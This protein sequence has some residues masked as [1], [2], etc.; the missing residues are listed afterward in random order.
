MAKVYA[1]L[2]I[3]GCKTIN[4]VPE[5]IKTDVQA[6]LIEMGY[7]ELAEGDN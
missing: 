1:S 4:D 5:K 7:P 2:I 3:K 6:A